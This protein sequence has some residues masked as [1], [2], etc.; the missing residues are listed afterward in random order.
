MLTILVL[1]FDFELITISP[2]QATPHDSQFTAALSFVFVR[3]MEF[4]SIR[5]IWNTNKDLFEISMLLLQSTAYRS[6]FA[7]HLYTVV[8]WLKTCSSTG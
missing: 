6:M 4:K 1:A 5:D 7:D 3:S 2:A 8:N